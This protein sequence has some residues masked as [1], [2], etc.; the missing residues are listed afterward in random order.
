MIVYFNDKYIP[1]DEVKISPFDRA[2]LFSDGVYEAL[3]TYNCKLFRLDDH[4][5]RL[6]YSLKELGINFNDF[7]L[8]EN[9]FTH[10]ADINN[11]KTEYSVYI[12]IS[13]GVSYP[14]T[15]NY[16]NSLTPNVFAFAKLIKDNNK[17]KNIG[18]KVIL[19]KD[20][21]WL[22]CDI[23]ST[24]LLPS[25]MASQKAIQ[26]NAF[27]AILFRDDI[28]TEGS[29]TNFFAVKNNTVF[30]AP[31]SNYILNGITRKVVLELCKENKIDFCEE[32]INVNELKNFD[33]FFITGTTTEVTPIIKIDDWIVS[34]GKPGIITLKIQELF[35]NTVKQV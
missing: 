23:K 8:I 21:R 6:K 29:H 17:E 12:Q 14:R 18:V 22:R 13:R 20:L 11:I 26:N 34:D 19:E 24:S 27:E 1:H 28:I 7:N 30:T 31:L 2:F 16:E 33:E 3:R 9:I 15:H 5:K 32:Q 4:L 35:F 25:V 10:L